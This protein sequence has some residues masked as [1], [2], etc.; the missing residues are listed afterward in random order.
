MA[1]VGGSILTLKPDQA[2]GIIMPEDLLTLDIE[3]SGLSD[4]SYPISIGISGSD[5]QSWYWLVCPLEDWSHWDD[6]AQDNHGISRDE[7]IEEGRDA[8][9]VSREINAVFNGKTLIVDSKWDSFWINRLYSDL[10]VEPSFS[11]KHLADVFPGSVSSAVFDEIEKRDWIH[12]AAS[13]AKDL[14]DIILRHAEGG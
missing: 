9:L 8:F 4:D 3:S 5:N 1:I 7:L 14:R 2:M 13:D 6:F 10:G 12:N 11:V